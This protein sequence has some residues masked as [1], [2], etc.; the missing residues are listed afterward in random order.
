ME[1]EAEQDAIDNQ[2]R[3][4]DWGDEMVPVPVDDTILSQLVDMGFSDVRGRKSIVHGKNLEGSTPQT[5]RR[6]LYIIDNLT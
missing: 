2:K 1:A 3:D 5:K 6:Y 4:D